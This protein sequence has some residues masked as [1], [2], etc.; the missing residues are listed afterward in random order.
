NEHWGWFDELVKKHL[1]PE[2]EGNEPAEPDSGSQPVF[3]TS[4]GL[5]AILKKAGFANIEIV[6]EKTDFVYATEEEHWS[7]LWSHGARVS[8]EK[9]EQAN[10]ADGLQRFKA[11]VFTKTQSIKRTDGIHQLFPVLFALAT[12]ED[13]P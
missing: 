13:I 2:P 11:D 9:I 8:L 12:K 6:F 3:D 5:D 4:E 1:P 10:G 7:S